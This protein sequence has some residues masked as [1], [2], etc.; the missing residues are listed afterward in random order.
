M[1]I[2]DSLKEE[3]KRDELKVIKRI[4]KNVKAFYS[5][6]KRTSKTKDT[7]GPLQNI[8]GI[9]TNDPAKMANILQDQYQ[10]VF[11]IPS[12]F[13][14]ETEAPD[15]NSVPVLDDFEFDED[16]IIEAVNDMSRYSA[17]G[18][19]KFPAEILKECK[20]YLAT[21]LLHLWRTSLNS[22]K[23]PLQHLQQVIVPI[24]KKGDRSLPE[25]YRPVSLTSHIIKVFER[26]MRKKILHHLESNNLLV[27]QQ[28][29]FREK[30]NCL[31][32]LLHHIEDILQSLEN[33]CNQD[34]IYLDFSKAFDKVDHN[35]LRHKLSKL[36][37]RGKF[38]SWLSA[39]LSNRTQVVLVK[40]TKSRPV[41]VLSGVP[42]GTVLGPLLFI[43]FINDITDSIKNS[44]IKIFADDSKLSR[45]IKS[46]EDRQSC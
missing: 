34:V 33:D 11:S 17:T 41:L 37:V 7:I 30:R 36:G 22:S 16:D 44:S 1:E 38:L 43:I 12:N 2:R 8:D 13:K 3:K 25:N 23:I 27:D 26:V 5:Y 42:Q 24:Y 21:P 10:K 29:G 20:D 18:P 46:A 14:T 31:T 19:D 9:L 45:R 15:N 32:Q 40:G 4:K 28:H 6:A 39:F 35:I